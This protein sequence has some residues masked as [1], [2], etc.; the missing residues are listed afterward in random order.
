M[1]SDSHSEI[2]DYLLATQATLDKSAFE[3][4][5]RTLRQRERWR[6]LQ[7]LHYQRAIYI[8]E[9]D[10]KLEQLARS[11]EI[12][13]EQL[14]DESTAL[15][16]LGEIL[17]KRPDHYEA[18]RLKRQ[19]RRRQGAIED[20]VLEIQEQLTNTEQPSLK[21]RLLCEL[22]EIQL[23][24]PDKKEEAAISYHRAFV[25]DPTNLAAYEAA[26][27]LYLELNNKSRLLALLK[28]FLATEPPRRK[29]AFL[30]V[31]LGQIAAQLRQETPQ[32]IASYFREALDLDPDNK[33]AR[34]GLQQLAVSKFS[35][36]FSKFVQSQKKS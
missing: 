17:E 12:L 20:V 32:K 19:I 36:A 31:E 3:T 14:D 28:A 7:E 16:F 10:E 5:C 13:I 9:E 24:L 1:M 33:G 15:P 26:H 2:R 23:E 21:S 34:E 8:D 18:L 27:A 6:E 35:S 30:L 22:A 29:K 11:A 25:I 4:L